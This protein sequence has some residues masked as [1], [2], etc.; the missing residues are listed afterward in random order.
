M[1]LST[2]A[3]GFRATRRRSLSGVL[4]LGAVLASWAVPVQPSA[5]PPPKQLIAL[6]N[7][8]QET[9]PN[10]STAQGVGH[11]TYTDTT[12]MLCFAISYQG[13]GSPEL[14]AHIHGPGLPGVAAGIAYAL[15]AG[16][17]K[18]GC[19]GP[20]TTPQKTQLLKN[21]LYI[22][23]HSTTLPGG[24]IRGQIMRIK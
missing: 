9:P 5:A 14:V 6:I 19:V 3:F 8:A 4:A 2:A 18:T 16:N 7:A 1:Q 10:G 23:I 15:P 12:K 24:E 17:P 13:L 11:L 21:E 22:N 20:L